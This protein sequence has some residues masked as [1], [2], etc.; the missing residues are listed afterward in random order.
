[1]NIRYCSLMIALL[2]VTILHL[3]C[4]PAYSIDN[5]IGYQH[6]S[7]DQSLKLEEL[8]HQLDTESLKNAQDAAFTSLKTML[9]QLVKADTLDEKHA[10]DLGLEPNDLVA[11]TSSI[12][13]RQIL[14]DAIRIF[15]IRLKDLR[16]FASGQTERNLLI[17]TH[18]VL[19][20]VNTGNDEK[21]SVVVRSATHA[22]E[23]SEHQV[24]RIS[25]R[26]TKWGLP[27]LTRRLTTQQ[28]CLKD[29][30][31]NSKEFSLVSIPSLNR[32]FLGYK[33]N[34]VIKLL[35]LVADQGCEP[36]E[37]RSAKEVFLGLVKEAE[38]VGDSPR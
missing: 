38:S 11:L 29:R 23:T 26:A 5:G 17:D 19:F 20:P 36:G 22:K 32:N 9:L 6:S 10:K 27:N 28:K 15:H 16:N 25:W 31:P 8:G 7:N 2:A 30:S 18:Q 35:P 12:G 34:G 24:Q 1:M 13:N 3:V 37:P 33:D 21:L 4:P 14:S